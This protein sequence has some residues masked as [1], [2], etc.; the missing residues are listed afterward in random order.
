MNIKICQYFVGKDEKYLE[1]CHEV[2]KI[3]KKYAEIQ[4]YAYEFEYTDEDVIKTYYDG[5]CTYKEILAYKLHFVYNNLM[6]GDYD[7]IVFLDADAAISNPTMKIEDLIDNKHELFLSRGNE[8]TCQLVELK[9]IKNSINNLYIQ[10]EILYNK[11]WDEIVKQY[12][13][14]YRDFEWMSV[15][16]ILFNAGFIIVKNTKKMKELFEDSLKIQYL[17]MDTIDRKSVV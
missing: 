6:F 11:Y 9:R 10:K 4:G 12:P 3:N 16:N 2:K 15:G 5:E 1:L 8:I 14:L 13:T 17:L 7:L